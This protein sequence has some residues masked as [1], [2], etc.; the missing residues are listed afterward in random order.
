MDPAGPVA[1]Y[2][3]SDP[4]MNGNIHH[5]LPMHPHEQ[6]GHPMAPAYG[7]EYTQSPVSAGPHPYGGMT[8]GPSLGQPG[9]RPKKGNRATQ[10]CDVCR[11]RKAK[12]DEGRP[13]CGFCVEQ[14]LTCNYQ[15]V[16]PAKMDRA[17]QAILEQLETQQKDIKELRQ[18]FINK[19][20][21]IERLLS[22]KPV[23]L[24]N[25]ASVSEEK[26]TKPPT[27][28][29][30]S[31]N[32]PTTSGQRSAPS[33]VQPSSGNRDQKLVGASPSG[34]FNTS[35]TESSGIDFLP[36]V[37]KQ[38]AIHTE[39]NTAAQKL[40]RWPAIKALLQ[41]CQPLH[42]TESSENYVFNMELNKG[43]LHLYGK[44][45]GPDPGDGSQLTGAASP[46]ASSTSTPSD[47]ASDASSPASPPELLWGYG[48]NPFVGDSKSE[49]SAG[50]LNAD[51]T[52]KLD[53]K[54]VSMLHSSY[55]AHIQILHPI[56][57]ETV[58][59]KNIESFKRR[60]GS[61]HDPG[62]SKAG[63]AVPATI[64]ALRDPSGGLN[65]PLKRKLS[66]G[67]YW[68][69]AGVAQAPPM[70]PKPMLE[71]SPATAVILLVMALGKICECREALPGPVTSLSKDA[72]NYT[73]RSYSP[74]GFRADSPPPFSIRPS[75]TS[76][77]STAP[78][79]I[80]FARQNHM[81]PR[82]FEA[83][84]PLHRKNL[85]VIPG[86][87]YYAQATDILGNMTGSHDITY[88]QCCLLAGLYAGQL[89]N[90]VESL[91]WIQSAARGCCILARDPTL[92]SYPSSRQNSI[93]LAFYTALQ[94]ESD[95]L[96]EIDFPPSGIR[97]ISGVEY[98]H[99]Y[100][101][102]DAQPPQDTPRKSQVMIFYTYQLHLRNLLDA[103]Q[104]DVY[105]PGKDLTE[106]AKNKNLR[107][108]LTDW[109]MNWRKNLPEELRWTDGDA[110]VRGDVNQ[111]R[112]RGKYY[113]A[114]YIIHRPMLHYALELEATGHLDHYMSQ[115]AEQAFGSMR[116]PKTPIDPYF[117][118]VVQAACTTIQAAVWSTQAFDGIIDFR[119]LIV[120]NIF[121][122][123]HAQFGNMLVLSAAYKSKYF[124]SYIS[125]EPKKTMQHLFKR[126][127][128]LLGS[129]K[130]ISSTLGHDQFILQCLQ[131]LVFEGED[132][133]PSAPAA[134]PS[135]GA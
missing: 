35:S 1:G 76:S 66:D 14:D 91:V 2:P 117:E 59:S 44:G 51:N 126:T 120:T 134:A 97:N 58:L 99:G 132:D 38:N 135:F 61:P 6:S 25:A 73:A 45:Q 119:R 42:F 43:P 93:R 113:G 32:Q 26:D 68:A 110:P 54:T 107:T 116:P 33:A 49:N 67:Q 100:F 19:L 10:A 125:D 78:S 20:E 103:T 95:I 39:H 72:L 115:A 63:F 83:G 18:E 62:S 94:L 106:I 104:Q 69:E 123:A 37:A 29:S 121:G 53:A 46:A 87:A 75:P 82:A 50:G 28:H 56:L 79:P 86:L 31:P 80:G 27:V 13:R 21:N 102:E 64:D 77:Y 129:L 11:T 130:P 98:P 96:A 30:G 70:T 92:R 60:Y 122:T 81:S 111:A 24:K 84:V 55:M 17:N 65:R 4:H 23:N 109:L 16:A 48:I 127:I 36:S 40:F 8:Y 5:G 22:S 131:D 108:I 89:A 88:V 57:D 133:L 41:R 71:R 85:D 3:S 74:A 47:E 12:C 112:L 7:P 105:P 118:D 90:A 52:L 9:M 101:P 34:S 128:S 114:L 124:R 15:S